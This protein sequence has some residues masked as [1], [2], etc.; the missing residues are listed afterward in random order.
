M[1]EQE[2][3]SRPVNEDL[4]FQRLTWIAERTAWLVFAAIALVALTGLFGGGA[5][6]ETTVANAEGSLSVQYEQL[7]RVTRLT[8]FR[9]R[10]TPEAAAEPRLRLS[11][12]FTESFEFTSLQP[13]PVSSSG[14]SDG[15]EYTFA[16]PRGELIVELWA[17]PRRAGRLAVEAQ[18]GRD[19]ALRLPILVYP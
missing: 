1:H 3:R 12:S 5:L 14:G 18:R 4:R 19:G 8:H 6:S 16:K 13:A 17:H 2:N 11:P 15:V 9:F 7:Q 10:L